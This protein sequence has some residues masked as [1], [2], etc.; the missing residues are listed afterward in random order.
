MPL[1]SASA[2]VLRRM[3][4]GETDR[5][6]WLYTRERGKVS[7]IA[8]GVRKP[9][10]RLAAAT[11]TLTYG[12]YQLATG[13]TLDVITQAE[14]KESF[15][16][17]HSE[18]NRLAHATYLAE[19]QDCFVEE[20]EPAVDLFEL[21]L[22]ALYLMERPN[23]PEKITRMFELQF[24]GLIGYEPSL[25]KCVRCRVDRTGDVCFSPSMGGVVCAEC[26]PL[27]ED[28]IEISADAADA[29]RRLLTAEAPDVERME[30]AE[31]AMGQI[32]RAMR[33]YM[34]YRAE[35]PIKSLEFLQTLEVCR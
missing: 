34:R 35:R 4:F 15:P 26:G 27:P 28:A 18:L 29:M 33:W 10:S 17:I 6:V 2:I 16:R 22:S 5:I 23:G 32:G 3:S 21:L 30:I 12:R 25:D 19:L 7:A 31:R 1:Y 11:E 24:A 20:R 13:K 14:V 8:K 9:V